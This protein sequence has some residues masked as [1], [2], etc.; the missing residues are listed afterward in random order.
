MQVV[1]NCD[2]PLSWQYNLSIFLCLQIYMETLLTQLN[3][4]LWAKWSDFG[5]IT[6]EVQYFVKVNKD[7]L[8]QIMQKIIWIGFDKNLKAAHVQLSNNVR[9]LDG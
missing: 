8:S 6:L 3:Y 7:N 1:K 4:H 5:S 2:I 9:F